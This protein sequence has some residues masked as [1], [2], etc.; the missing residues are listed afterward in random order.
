MSH[1]ERREVA[2]QWLLQL[3][4]RVLEGKI[5]AHKLDEH[6]ANHA[7]SA[8]FHT[9]TVRGYPL[10]RLLAAAQAE[11][12]WALPETGAAHGKTM[13]PEAGPPGVWDPAVWNMVDHFYRS[14]PAGVVQLGNTGEAI[15]GSNRQGGMHKILTHLRWAHHFGDRSI[16]LDA[17]AGTGTPC[18][19]AALCT[20]QGLAIGIE[21]N[22]A[23]WRLSMDNLWH[24]ATH[25]SRAEQRPRVALL[26]A[27]IESIVTLEPS[28]H[29]FCFDVGIQ[30]GVRSWLVGL[31]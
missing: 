12:R 5:P 30:E 29:V 15:D 10:A 11:G 23:R 24:H 9:G 17:G 18:I 2:L 26:H 25:R 28:T 21:L 31:I 19:H 14:R 27:D 22:I 8:P 3:G 7:R 20:N 4:K 13:W 16:F 6:W 1:P